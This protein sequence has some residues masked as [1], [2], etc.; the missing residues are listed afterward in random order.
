[1]ETPHTLPRAA[2]PRL[3]VNRVLPRNREEVWAG[4]LL[5]SAVGPSRKLRNLGWFG[6]PQKM[7]LVS[8]VREVLGVMH[9]DFA[10]WQF[11]ELRIKQ[12]EPQS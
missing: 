10:F 6:D 12:P 2:L 5:A 9:S 4:Q 3:T 8:E 11:W 1:M 7:Q